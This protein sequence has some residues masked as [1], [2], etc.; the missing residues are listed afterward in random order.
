[1][2]SKF[3]PIIIVEIFLTLLWQSLNLS[4]ASVKH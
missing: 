4:G 2:L 3:Q 1:M